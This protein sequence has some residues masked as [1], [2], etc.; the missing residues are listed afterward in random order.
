VWNED[1]RKIRSKCTNGRKRFCKG[2]LLE[3][4]KE[5]LVRREDGSDQQKRDIIYLHGSFHVTGNANN[6]VKS[7]EHD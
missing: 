3:D 5:A 2:K 6:V 1:G 4:V 7:L